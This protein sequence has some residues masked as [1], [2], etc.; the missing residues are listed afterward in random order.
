ME[1]YDYELAKKGIDLFKSDYDIRDY[2]I[3]QR[4]SKDLPLFLKIECPI[5]ENV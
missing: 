4:F 2:K 5:S 3:L 1:T